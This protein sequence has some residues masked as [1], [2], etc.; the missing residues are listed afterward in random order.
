M[1]LA[2]HKFIFLLFAVSVFVFF[3]E[4]AV[5][6]QG[7]ILIPNQISV[8]LDVHMT[9]EA[10]M[11]T[12]DVILAKNITIELQNRGYAT[13]PGG[14]L[15]RLATEGG[16]SSEGV[17]DAKL[18]AKM[19][20]LAREQGSKFICLA[21]YV[22]QG[23]FAA[24]S[25][26]FWHIDGATIVTYTT[27]DIVGLAVYNRM[28]VAVSMFVGKEG[29]GKKIT[30]TGMGESGGAKTY[31]KE[32]ILYSKDEGCEVFI[33]DK[34]KLGVIKDGKLILPYMPLTVGSVI[35][36]AKKKVGYYDSSEEL[37]LTRE[38]N[39]FSLAPLEKIYGS[40]LVFTWTTS[41]FVGLG[42]G[43][44]GN[45]NE[46][47]IYWG[48]ENYFFLQV[49]DTADMNPVIHDD[50]RGYLLFKFRFSDRF[51]FTISYSF[52]LGII[53]SLLPI[54]D[55]PLYTD[56][57]FNPANIHLEYAVA[58]YV[59]FLRI[60]YKVA[61]GMGRNLLESGQISFAKGLPLFT[62]GV[63]TRW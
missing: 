37:S 47:F 38:K 52:G 50:L 16:L 32:I 53:F 1:V 28:N 39:E 15:A 45:L 24:L 36:I 18:S 20:E 7:N 31:V 41:Q 42:V 54:E 46:R 3:A 30:A 19:R 17:P 11:A 9:S 62:L 8:F 43:Y 58:D 6:A 29:E 33:K 63:I 55:S 49:N 13:V 5:F 59:I 34:E 44:I 2:V 25:V 22:E 56:F 12:Y 48:A 40:G 10:D 23:E 51:P 14:E 61:L 27:K 4:L 21:R 26:Y 35:V 60:E 57:Y